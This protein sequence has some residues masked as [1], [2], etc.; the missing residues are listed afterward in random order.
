VNAAAAVKGGCEFQNFRYYNLVSITKY[1]FIAME[2]YLSDAELADIQTFI[3][4]T[5]SRLADLDL[6][7]DVDDDLSNWAAH[8]RQAPGI[9]NIAA[10]HDPARSNIHPGNAFWGKLENKTGQIIACMAHKVVTTENLIDEV[11]SHRIFFNRRPIL[12]H[13]P[14]DLRIEQDV[15]LLSGRVG[16]GGGLWVHPNYRG[17]SLSGVL[18]RVMRNLSIRHFNINWNVSFIADT[19]SRTRMALEG[20]GMAHRTP[21]LKGIF[22]LYGKD[23]DMQMFYMSKDEMLSQIAME[24]QSAIYNGAGS[25]SGLNP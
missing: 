6:T 22:P 25:M 11:R 15:P 19:P 20:Y 2:T 23:R 5:R 7:L 9:L 21:L 17:Q 8:M 4:M 10:T 16:Y 13:Y 3:D 18:A 24:N 1:V 12:E 14:V